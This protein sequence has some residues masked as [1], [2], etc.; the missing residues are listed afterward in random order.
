LRNLVTV[1]RMI[2]VYYSNKSYR[3]WIQEKREK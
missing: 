3:F 1:D 2:I